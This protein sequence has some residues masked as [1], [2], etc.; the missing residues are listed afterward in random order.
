MLTPAEAKEKSTKFSAG[1]GKITEE[2]YRWVAYDRVYNPFE[3]EEYSSGESDTEDEMEAEETA[4]SGSDDHSVDS[5]ES[6][7]Q[8]MK[9]GKRKPK[10]KGHER[11]KRFVADVSRDDILR[12]MKAEVEDL[13]VKESKIR[14][15]INK[16]HDRSMANLGPDLGR[17]IREKAFKGGKHAK[18]L[19]SEKRFYSM[20]MFC[21]RHG[22]PPYT[23]QTNGLVDS[24]VGTGDQGHEMN[25][26]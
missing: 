13:T 9:K 17:D 1:F 18:R 10:G 26:D 12:I 22:I 7:L 16:F 4:D 24:V 14:K 15:L 20:I 11:K 8:R 6:K 2:E 25:L 3:W 19:T 23:K 21:T 5:E